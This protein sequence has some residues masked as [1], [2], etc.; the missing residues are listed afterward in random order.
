MIIAGKFFHLLIKSFRSIRKRL[1]KFYD[2]FFKKLVGVQNKVQLPAEFHVDDEQIQLAFTPCLRATLI[3][4]N[5]TRR[6][7]KNVGGPVE[8]DTLTRH[9][10]ILPLSF[11][12]SNIPR[13]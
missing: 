4:L 10:D 3:Q 5:L 12:S 9:Y 2:S 1:R 11:S 6:R 8:P 13:I 7:D